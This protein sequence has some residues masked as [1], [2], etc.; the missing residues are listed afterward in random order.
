MSDF[1]ELAVPRKEHMPPND[2]KWF[3]TV[4]L[5]KS[6]LQGCL[7]NT[8]GAVEAISA[9][10]QDNT[11]FYFNTLVGAHVSAALYYKSYGLEYPHQDAWDQ[12][13][14]ADVSKTKTPTIKSQVMR[15][16]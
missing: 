8:G 4:D 11:R 2:G 12:A 7:L 16:K 15:F 9:V 10:G 14:L 5:S 1:Y 3:V 6:N 13:I